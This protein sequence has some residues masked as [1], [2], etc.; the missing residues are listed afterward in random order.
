MDAKDKIKRALAQ[1]KMWFSDAYATKGIRQSAIGNRQSD[2]TVNRPLPTAKKAKQLAA[3]YEQ[4]KGCLACPLGKSRIKF[5]F[6]VG[7]PDSPLMFI[8]EGPGYDEDRKGEPFVGRA[9]QLL[10]KI[11][12]SMKLTREQVYIA[13]LVKC[14][15]MINPKTPEV[16]GNDRPPAPEEMETCKP[17][18]LEQ[19]RIIRPKVI[20][21]LGST[22]SK[23]M[24]QTQTPISKLR[25]VWNKLP[26]FPEIDAM[27]TYHPAALL[28]NPV[29]KKDV[30]VDMKRIMARLA[31]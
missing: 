13:N 9:G 23:A 6:G 29:L 14:H 17:I 3:L 22:S 24:L 21:L 8:G 11:I 19:I 7:N 25:G 12:E 2:P 10:T 18:L 27:P 5:V 15:P 4:Y 26:D 30:W 16:R 28:R 20:C 31:E 1:E